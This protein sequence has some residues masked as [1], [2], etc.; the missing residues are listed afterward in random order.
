MIRVARALG[1]LG[2]LGMVF[3][4]TATASC[5]SAECR[6]RRDCDVGFTCT[7]DGRC[8]DGGEAV[9]TWVSPEPGS[10]V[11]EIFD[12]ELDVKFRGASGE[13]LIDRAADNPGDPCAPSIPQRVIIPGNAGES[14]AQRIT[15]PAMRALGERFG[16][17]ATLRAGGGTDTAAAE[18]RGPSF[19]FGGATFQEPATPIV[20]AD[21]AL[22]AAVSAE[23]EQTAAH[24]WLWVEPLGRDGVGLEPSAREHLGLGI[25]RVFEAPAPLAR[26]AQIVWLEVQDAEGTR[27]CGRG[28]SGGGDPAAASGLELGLFYDSEDLALL[29]LRVRPGEGAS[30][31][32]FEAPGPGCEPVYETR[33][34]ARRGEEV[35]RVIDTAGTR[36]VD[37]AVVPAAAGGPATA[38]VRVSMNGEHVG[39]LGPFPIQPALGEVWL[40]GRVLVDGALVELQRTDD[41]VIGAPF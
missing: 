22:T 16:I 24:A 4:A 9:I 23:L 14:L 7:N 33:G 17:A 8:V 21:H 10:E 27:R 20:P 5:L 2:T 40:A 12:V 25:Q 3:A 26:G 41:V 1:A 31:C 34:P 11:Q 30:G 29:D 32:S 39:W 15:I 28:L 6:S 35:L 18:L 36:V 38:R 37:I 19:G 13:L